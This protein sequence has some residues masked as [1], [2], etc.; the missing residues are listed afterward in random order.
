[1]SPALEVDSLPLSHQ[2]SPIFLSSL[3]QDIQAALIFLPKILE[4]EL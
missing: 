2:G 1:M 3:A 4:P